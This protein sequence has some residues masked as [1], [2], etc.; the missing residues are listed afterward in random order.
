MT[1]EHIMKKLGYR[2][3]PD[4]WHQVWDSKGHMWFENDVTHE[5][6][7]VDPRIRP[8][9]DVDENHTIHAPLGSNPNL[10]QLQFADN[11]DSTRTFKTTRTHI[12][13]A[14]SVDSDGKISTHTAPTHLS[15]SL[16]MRSD[17]AAEP[18]DT[19]SVNTFWARDSQGSPLQGPATL[20]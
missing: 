9:N 10:Q 18:E 14:S 2:P 7:Y 1:Y 13:T 4:N 6:T 5:Q 12:E 8:D 20:V 19:Q 3:L 11:A 15:D 16:A 17:A